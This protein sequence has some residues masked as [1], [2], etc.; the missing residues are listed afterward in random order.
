MSSVL[1]ADKISDRGVEVL[2]SGG[3]EVDVKTGL[4]E[5]ELARAIPRYE[6]L[7]VRSAPEVTARVIEAGG[8]LKIIGR[9]GVGVD[10][11][12]V[13][14]ATARGI[15]VMNTPLGNTVSAA[16]H[17]LA[18]LLSL[19]R[20]VPAADASMKAA[21]WEKSRFIGVELGGKTLGVIG[22]G[23]IGS[24]VARVAKALRMHVVVQDPYLNPRRAEEL[25]VEPRD[26]DSLLKESDF[27]TIHVPLND[28]TRGMIGAR[29]LGLVKPGARLVNCARGGIV[30]EEAL[31]KALK[32]GRLA[33][34]AVD[35][36]EKEPLPADHL[37]RS[38][39]NVVLTPHLG[40]STAEAQEKVAEDLARQ[41]VD[42][43][44]R[45]E[46]RNPVNVEVT[47]KPRLAPFVR[48]AETLGR[49]AAQLAPGP[50]TRVEC[51][52]YGEV[53]KSAEDAHVVSVSALQGVLARVTDVRVNLVNVGRVAAS[54]GIEL[55]ERRA[56]TARNYKNVVAVKVLA[57]S[58]EHTVVGT[59]FEGSG[60]RIV[61]IDDLDI[62]L[63]PAPW[64]LV[65]FYPDRPGMV[66]KFGSILGAANINI[67]GMAVGRREK[68]GKA[69]VVVTVDDPVP[70][71]VVE[72]IRKTV[73]A[74]E[75]RRINLSPE[76]M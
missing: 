45:G 48:L 9:A 69:V 62:D 24:I 39:P 40:A 73:E 68:R 34:A 67:A 16:E 17:A 44:S 52:C 64:M 22:L 47:L 49:F 28:A 54:R 56:E 37:L 25:D 59:M 36:F 7:I 60:S 71:D 11:I 43:F 6:G 30:D 75:I 57:D 4:S 74:E 29:E 18:C 2:R 31:I 20:H 50:I 27:L 35:V 51:G 23:K 19:A 1:V 14:A 21:R 55:S 66:G 8:N 63:R 58:A 38:L 61:E 33:G 46:I 70:D 41:F 72:T 65:M 10:N 53:G 3:L 42:F 15:V 32:S 12:D 26:L 13:D 76:E 5:N